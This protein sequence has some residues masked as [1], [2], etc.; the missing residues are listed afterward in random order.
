[1][2]WL[3]LGV[4][5]LLALFSGSLQASCYGVVTA[6]GGAN[7]W[8]QVVKGAQTAAKEIDIAIITRGIAD[9]R[10]DEA[11]AL[12]IESMRQKGCTGFLLAPSS[13]ALLDTVTQYKSIGIPIV[14]VDRDM[15]G[16]RAA[17]LKT[18]NYR[19]GQL[20]A[21]QMAHQLAPGAKVGVFRTHQL[22]KTVAARVAGFIDTAND[23]GIDVVFN[24]LIGTEIGE[25]RSNINKLLLEHP[26]VDGL[27]SPN[28][29]STV[30]T[31]ASLDGWQNNSRPVHIGFDSNRYIVKALIAGKLAGF[32]V[33]DPYRMGYDGIKTLHR[34][35]LAQAVEEHTDIPAVFV[36]RDNYQS[37]G[38]AAKL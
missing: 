27:F 2:T 16:D 25:A 11:Q 17:V 21:N 18:N 34:I 22:D 23:M 20:A 4:F 32:V 1:M 14:F 9:E 28:E 6:G 10:N 12:I 24:E 37:A 13:T 7:Y 3:I 31:I 19:A 35:R 33:Q 29:N 36:N 30:A 8:Q 26:A 5:V 15:G 38:I